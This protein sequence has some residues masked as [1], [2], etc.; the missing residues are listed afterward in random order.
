MD[1]VVAR[2]HQIAN[3]IQAAN[4]GEVIDAI[5]GRLR[6]TSEAAQSFATN[7]EAMSRRT[8]RMQL[9]HKLGLAEASLING[10][11]LANPVPGAKQVEEK[12][13][14]IAYAK[15]AIC[16]LYTSPSPRDS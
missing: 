5:V 12:L 6:T 1:D 14:L 9:T 2:L 7:A 10:S 11:V 4:K 16:L 3:D 8:G 13:A 15:F